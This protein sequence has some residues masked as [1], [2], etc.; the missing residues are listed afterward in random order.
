MNV[1]LLV[2]ILGIGSGDLQAPADLGFDTKSLDRIDA[3]VSEAIASRAIPGAVVL[4]GRGGKTA[5]RRS[6]G[7]RK[8]GADPEAMTVDT[9]FDLASLTKPIVTATSILNLADRGK[10]AIGDRLGTL[11][12][13]FDNLGKGAITVEQLLRHRS[14]LIADNP[15]SDYAD[16][17]DEAWKRLANL[18]LRAAPGEKFLYSDVNYLILG[19]IVERLAGEPSTASHSHIIVP[20]GM[21]DAGFLPKNHP[22]S[23]LRIAPTVSDVPRGVV[24]DPRSRALGG[25]AGH[26]GLFGTADDLARFANM[27]LDDGKAEDGTVI[28]RPE[29]VRSMISPGDTPAGQKRG[30][31]WDIDTPFSAPRGRVF[32]PGSFGHTGFTGTSLWIDPETRT[33]VIVLTSRLQPDGKAPSPTEVRRRIATI[34]GESIRDRPPR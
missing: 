28:L 4:V 14:G 21:K 18:D 7:L 19:R 23:E 8:V 22:N 16:G 1:A 13:E 34:V 17:P 11:L 3:V 32:G 15:E 2:A 30:L 12:P 9:I 26:A 25:V 6:Y 29:T 10:L 31:G 27:I 33:F 20:L 24:H 5:L